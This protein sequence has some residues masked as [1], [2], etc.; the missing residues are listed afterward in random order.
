MGP[1]VYVADGSKYVEFTTYIAV[2]DT[3]QEVLST[4]R[5]AATT[6]P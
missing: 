5:A 2:G 4:L 6:K 1:A 3:P